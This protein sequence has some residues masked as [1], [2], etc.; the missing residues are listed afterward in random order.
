MLI[1]RFYC[2]Q[3][4][5]SRKNLKNLKTFLNSFKVIFLKLNL[6]KWRIF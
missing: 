5:L 2:T 1:N 4:L 6:I 3:Y